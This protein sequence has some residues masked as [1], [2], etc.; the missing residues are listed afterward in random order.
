MISMPILILSTRLTV[1]NRQG[2]NKMSRTKTTFKSYAEAS[3]FVKKL[4]LRTMQEWIDYSKGKDSQGRTRPKD[5]P[6]NPWTIY[7][8]ELNEQ[9]KKFSINEFIGSERKVG[10]KTTRKAKA[11][12]AKTT[13]TRKPK[14]EE[15]PKVKKTKVA[16]TRKTKVKVQEPRTSVRTQ[17]AKLQ[18]VAATRTRKPAF[19]ELTSEVKGKAF[20]YSKARG[21]LKKMNVKNQAD[22]NAL[23]R[24]KLLP[25]QLPEHPNEAFKDE[26]KSWKEFLNVA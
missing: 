11:Q 10:V 4:H 26:W 15:A 2:E 23:V 6:S 5:I 24:M 14:A 7:A 16:S 25:K 9:G 13:R 8:P 22:F 20:T 18:E 17:K 1:A 12:D 19:K 3:A 21:I